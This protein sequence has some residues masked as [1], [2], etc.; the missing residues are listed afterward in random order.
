[1]DAI[2]LKVPDRVPVITSM[3]YFPAKYVGIPCSAAYYDYDAWFDAYRK[4]LPDFAA[5]IIFQQVRLQQQR[6]VT[7][8]DLFSASPR[9]RRTGTAS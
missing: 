6:M 1:M 9:P 7:H 4:T 3:G 5:D 2:Q 8:D